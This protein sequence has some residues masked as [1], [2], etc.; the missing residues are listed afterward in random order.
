VRIITAILIVLISISQNLYASGAFPLDE[1]STVLIGR[2][3][4]YTIR[5]K[6]TLIELARNYD[7]GFNEIAA[8][9]RDIDPWVPPRGSRIII[10]TSWLIPE[11]LKEGIL[12]NLA[13]M[14][15]YFF[16]TI[17]NQKY[18]ST[19]PI[20][21]GREG[22]NTPTGLFRITAI[23]KEPV[24]KIPEDIRQEYPD[25]P[26]LVP[27][28]PAN[29]L[30]KYWFQLSIKGYGIHGTNKPYGIGRRVSHGCIRLYPEDI[31]VLSRFVK[32]GTTVKIIDNPVKT[33]LYNDKLYIE[34]HRSDLS[35]TELISLTIKHLSRKRLLKYVDTQLMIQAIKN[36]TGLPAVISSD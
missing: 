2:P 24:W 32:P 5:D 3:E 28:G 19:Y 9:N 6:E 14:R 31:E 4:I 1:H 36:A 22:F 15:L 17:D 8:A 35:N 13:E 21:I 16:F 30:G 34:V 7:V 23:I 29:P 27:P 33:G 11:I 20:G 26:A 18:I 25:L 12:I 10:P